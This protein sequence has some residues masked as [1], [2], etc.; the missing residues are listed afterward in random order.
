MEFEKEYHTFLQYHMEQSSGERLRRLREGHGYLEK[1]FL[2]KIWW[3]AVG[4]FRYLHPEYEVKDFV[5]GTRF[6]DFAYLRP[7]YRIKFGAD[8]Y[9]PHLKNTDRWQFG[10][11]LMRQNHLILDGW[12][13]FRFS[14]DDILK[15]ERRCQQFILHLI[16]RLYGNDNADFDASLLNPKE[17]EIVRF[18]AAAMESV[19]PGLL[20]DFLG[21]H[22]E[23]ARLWLNRL[24]K[25][26][27]LQGASG[28]SRIRSYVLSAAG[29]QLFL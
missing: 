22:P 15:K 20:A 25:K 1:Q 17:K 7:P 14:S 2:Q 27:F 5:D 18:V 21:I 6:L 29:K 24:H 19:T 8:G 11:N 13:V 10:D 26:G 16:G 4:H 3:P 12:K 9:G 28:R 23:N